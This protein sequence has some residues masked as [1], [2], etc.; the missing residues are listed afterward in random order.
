MVVYTL[1]TLTLCPMTN[2][3]QLL[4]GPMNEFYVHFYYFFFYL[5]F[6]GRLIVAC[7]VLLFLLFLGAPWCDRISLVWVGL[8]SAAFASLAQLGVPGCGG[9]QKLH[10]GV[11]VSFSSVLYSLTHPL[12]NSNRFECTN[13]CLFLILVWYLLVCITV[14]H[15]LE[16]Q[17]LSLFNT[18]TFK[19]AWS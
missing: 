13:F 14:L 11:I 15:C 3:F 17:W 19:D 6:Q 1:L 7:I 5:Y 12:S 8:P 10:A 16:G 18:S 2:R 9:R 4:S